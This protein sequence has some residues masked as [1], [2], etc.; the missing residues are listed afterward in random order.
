MVKAKQVH[1]K[2]S[3]EELEDLLLEDMRERDTSQKEKSLNKTERF[4]I[5]IRL[6]ISILLTILLYFVG[7]F[8]SIH[9]VFITI[10]LIFLIEF[11]LYLKATS[12]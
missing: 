6:F 9:L 12:K 3:L 10:F 11:I 7:I 4:R 8:D 1:E 5:K 2:N